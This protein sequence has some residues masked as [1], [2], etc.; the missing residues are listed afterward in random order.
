[1]CQSRNTTLPIR[2][3]HQQPHFMGRSPEDVYNNCTHTDRTQTPFELWYGQAP[4]AV[5]TAFN[6]L[7]YPKMKE[8]LAL[9]QQWRNDAHIA[10]E[11]A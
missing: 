2:L 4:Q 5:P 3:L 1:M 8:R 7:N 11:Y 10:H 9:L 6:Y